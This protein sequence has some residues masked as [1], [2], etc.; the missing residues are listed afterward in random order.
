MSE[1]ILERNYDT[2]NGTFGTVKR[3]EIV[4]CRDCVKSEEWQGRMLCHRF[5][6]SSHAGFPVEPDGFCA[7]GEG[8]VEGT[9][10]AHEDYSFMF[11]CSH[12]VS[13]RCTR[14]NETIEKCCYESDG[15]CGKVE[16]W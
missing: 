15:L 3:E 14:E 6:M 8:K 16:E 10:E 7:W 4:R 9:N 5:S 1:Y 13:G 11:K 12:E 2:M